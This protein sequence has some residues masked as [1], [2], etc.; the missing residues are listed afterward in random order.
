MSPPPLTDTAGGKTALTQRVSPPPLTDTAG[1]KTA[2]TQR[3]SRAAELARQLTDAP[4]TLS[5]LTAQAARL[6]PLLPEKWD[7]A[8]QRELQQQK[9]AADQLLLAVQEAQ[10]ALQVGD[11]R[12]REGG[13]EL[14]VERRGRPGISHEGER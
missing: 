6:Q 1:G 5:A 10:H 4:T 11:G 12:G 9:Y 7:A 8:L 14:T 13:W 3:V 2:L